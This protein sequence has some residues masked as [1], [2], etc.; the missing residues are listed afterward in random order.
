MKKIA[1][2]LAA[3]TTPEVRASPVTRDFT[4]GGLVAVAE[5][6]DSTAIKAALAEAEAVLDGCEALLDA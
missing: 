6:E 5:V 2:Q 3:G 1:I 4:A